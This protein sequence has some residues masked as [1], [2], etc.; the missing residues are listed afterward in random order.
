MNTYE[1]L[2]MSVQSIADIYGLVV[3]VNPMKNYSVKNTELSEFNV[4][5]IKIT[6]VN[7]LSLMQPELSPRKYT[8]FL[9]PYDWKKF[10]KSKEDYDIFIEFLIARVKKNIIY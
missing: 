9:L 10:Q 3:E 5:C 1:D 8:Y 4:K 2:C 7:D 6:F